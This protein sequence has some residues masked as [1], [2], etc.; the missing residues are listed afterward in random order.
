MSVT[1]YLKRAREAAAL[2]D[3]LTGNERAKLLEIAETWLK[4][5]DDAAK[6]AIKGSPPIAPRS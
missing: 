1:D 4:L 6:E 5:A 2:A 3:Q